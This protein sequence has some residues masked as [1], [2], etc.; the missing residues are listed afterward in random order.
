MSSRSLGR[1]GVLPD[2]MISPEA[3]RAA[4]EAAIGAG[5]VS[6][7][8]WLPWLHVVNELAATITAIGGAILMVWSLGKAFG[9]WG[10]KERH[11]RR[12]HR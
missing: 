11:R 8:W 3:A 2:R 6:S 9:L 12:P 5:G 10:R 1:R 7:L 4:G